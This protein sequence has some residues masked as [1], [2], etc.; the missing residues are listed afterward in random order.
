M[1]ET[2]VIAPILLS[3]VNRGLIV[4]FPKKLVA[5]EILQGGA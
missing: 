2:V 1:G 4:F 5:A 3:I